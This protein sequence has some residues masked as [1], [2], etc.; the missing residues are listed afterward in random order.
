[1]AAQPRLHNIA[2]G[3]RDPPKID[4][5]GNAAGE[6]AGG[7]EPK[8]N[9]TAGGRSAP[10]VAVKKGRDEKPNMPAIMLVGKLRTA[11]LYVCTAL[12]KLPR[13]TEMR[14]SVPSSCACKLRKFWF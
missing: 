6:T 3:K 8:L 9:C 10:A 11:V 5:Y 13:S 14:F 12:L 2:L 1:M 7:G 4:I